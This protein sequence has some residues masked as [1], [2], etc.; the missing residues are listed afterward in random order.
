MIM[1]K[2]IIQTSGKRKNVCYI[3]VVIAMLMATILTA[4]GS[5]KATEPST[6]A[7]T[8]KVETAKEEVAEPATPPE[9]EEVAE[10]EPTP[11]PEDSK[12]PGID[13]ESTLPGEEWIESFDDTAIEE[14]LIIVYNDETNKKIIVNEDDELEFSKSSDVLALYTPDR[15]KIS[16]DILPGGFDE[17]RI[18]SDVSKSKKEVYYKKGVTSENDKQKCTLTIT[19]NGEMKE[20]KFTLNLVE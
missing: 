3:M 11:T 19:I 18:E 10:P 17:T 20:Y 5:N 14:P 7:E 9:I 1:K 4:C 15:E 13:M 2:R 12:Y 8:T 6:E 16:L